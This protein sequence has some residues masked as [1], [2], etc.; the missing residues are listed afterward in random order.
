VECGSGNYAF[1][2]FYL[3]TCCQKLKVS[4]LEGVKPGTLNPEPHILYVH[5]YLDVYRWFNL[6]GLY[7]VKN[8]ENDIIGK[9][10]QILWFA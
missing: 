4:G 6:R 2:G 1:N 8:G 3:T 10:Q 5:L 9:A 7:S